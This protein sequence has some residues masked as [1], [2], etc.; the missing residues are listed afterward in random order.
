MVKICCVRHLF[1]EHQELGFRLI[2]ALVALVVVIA[3]ALGGYG[4]DPE[5]APGQG[6]LPQAG[7]IRVAVSGDVSHPGV[8]LLPANNVAAGVIKMAGVAVDRDN[9]VFKYLNTAV[10]GDGDHIRLKSDGA[11]GLSI[12]VGRMDTQSRL[13]MGIPLDINRIT[14]TEL[15]LLP[16]V[17]PALASNIVAHR[18]NIGGL[19]RVDQLHDVEGIGKAKYDRLIKY[20]K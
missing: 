13:I 7:M 5:P 1:G 6:V 16:G 14:E 20:F 19:M 10:P 15:V 17:G 2:F 3:A 8:Y 12:S 18:Q 9:A 11:G 4:Y